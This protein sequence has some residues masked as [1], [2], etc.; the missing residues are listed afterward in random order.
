[1]TTSE[2]IVIKVRSQAPLQVKEDKLTIKVEVLAISE[3]SE[4]SGDK[5]ILSELFTESSRDRKRGLR[6]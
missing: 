3:I 1:M 2:C 5:R 4:A 6:K